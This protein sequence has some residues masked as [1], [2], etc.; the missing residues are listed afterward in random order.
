MRRIIVAITGASS[1]LLGIRLLEVL[2]GEAGIETHLVVS[3]AAAL[4]LHLEC[5]DWTVERVRS[6]AHVHHKES[7]LA[8]SIASGSYPVEAMVVIPC[9]MKTLAA[10]AHGYGANL[11]AR[12]ADVTLKERRRLILVP[13][14]T[15]LHLGHLRA[16]TA[17]AEMGAVIV[18]PVIT[19]YHRPKTVLDVVDHTVGKVLDLLGIDHQLFPRWEGPAGSQDR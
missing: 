15:P 6:L 17:L 11:V 3:R 4:T 16:M 19:L 5:D 18:P 14:E 2:G 12:A 9:S 7:D 1:T 10:V 13:R 8:A